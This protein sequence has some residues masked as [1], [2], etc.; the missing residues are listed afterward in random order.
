MNLLTVSYSGRLSD[1]DQS[2]FEKLLKP[3]GEAL[4]AQVLVLAEGI[5]ATLTHDPSALHARLDVLVA[6][7][8]GLVAVNAALLERLP[9]PDADEPGVADGAWPAPLSRPR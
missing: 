4:D 1:E 8:E 7:I 6:S 3:Y 9:L 2:R 5:E